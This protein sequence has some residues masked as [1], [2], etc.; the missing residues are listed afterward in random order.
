MYD[1]IDTRRASVAKPRVAI[2]WLGSLGLVLASSL[3]GL[4]LLEIGCRLALGGP[5]ALTQWQ[6]LVLKSRVEARKAQGPD[7]GPAYV[8]DPR[9]GYVNKPDYHSWALNYDSHGFRAMPPLRAGGVQGPPIL[10]T[11]D[12]YTKGDEV[13]DAESWPAQ[14]Q[15][16]L[17]WR[18]INAGVGA[19]GLDQ[20][21]LLTEQ[22]VKEQKPAVLV[23]GFIADDVRRA[24]MSRLWGREKS[25]FE[26]APDKFGDGKLVLRNVPVPNPRHPRETL[27]PLQAAFGWSV[28]LDTVLDRLRLR[29]QWHADEARALWSGSGE[30]LACPLMRR[31]AAL[32]VP[33]LVV[34]Q[35]L[36]T[37]WDSPASAAEERRVTGVVL[38][39][40]EQAGLATLD[41]FPLFDAAIRAGGRGSVYGNWHPNWH[42][43]R[44]IG[45]Q[46]AQQLKRAKLVPVAG[47]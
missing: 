26:L 20:T 45:E 21:V 24:E 41:V 5:Q 22:L 42:G 47:P 6:N 44:L 36:P 15:T 8:H 32:G 18:T 3:V 13:G 37:A 30:R 34:A 16:L 14:L 12:S 17:G 4:M 31:V 7:L 19:Y 38:K 2:R 1:A 29:N 40:A 10:A 9:L 27:T 33:T 25:Y 46:V 39:C 11:G 43:Y 35:Y 28:L 23:L